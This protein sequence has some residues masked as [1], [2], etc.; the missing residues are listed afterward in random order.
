[1]KFYLVEFAATLGFDAKYDALTIEL[2]NRGKTKVSQKLCSRAGAWRQRLR[3][4]DSQ[5]GHSLER[6]VT[7][8]S[9]LRS[10]R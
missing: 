2:L 1:M 3:V 7:K 10:C 6:D 5:E 4:F 9:A 8:S